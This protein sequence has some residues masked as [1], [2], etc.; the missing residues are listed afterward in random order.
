M[1]KPKPLSAKQQ[2][3]RGRWASEVLDDILARHP[4]GNGQHPGS[5][6]YSSRAVGK[7]LGLSHTAALN[8]LRGASVPTP[9]QTIKLAKLAGRDPLQEV[10]IAE[11]LRT[12]DK[13]VREVYVQLEQIYLTS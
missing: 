5:V 9:E 6:T 1:K 4:L 13:S 12:T 7:L 11:Q 3:E 2:R 8:W 10:L